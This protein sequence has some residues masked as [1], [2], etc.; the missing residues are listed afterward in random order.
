ME[1]S[2]IH[3]NA[4]IIHHHHLAYRTMN[5]VWGRKATTHTH[6]GECEKRVTQL[7]KRSTDESSEKTTVVKNIYP[8]CFVSNI[9]FAFCT[10]ANALIQYLIAIIMY[11]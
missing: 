5:R 11:N 6:K 7:G 4:K 10:F 9:L 8:L 2:L 3:L 1:S